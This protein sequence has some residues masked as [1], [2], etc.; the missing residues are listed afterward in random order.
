MQSATIRFPGSYLPTM[1]QN[2]ILDDGETETS[3]TQLTAA[4]FINAV[5]ALE[6]ARQMLRRDAHT[7]VAE[8]ERPM[9]AFVFC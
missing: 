1:Q 7:I 4:T 6:D 5:E 2:G 9:R 3:A 8:G